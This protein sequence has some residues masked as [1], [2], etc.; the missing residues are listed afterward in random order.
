MSSRCGRSIFL[1]MFFLSV[2][3]GSG[4]R[5]TESTSSPVSTTPVNTAPVNTTPV[6]GGPGSS[7]SQLIQ[8]I[9]IIMQENRTFDHMFNGFPGADTVQGGMNGNVQ[10]PLTQIRLADP[11]NVYNTHFNWW[12]Q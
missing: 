11:G 2:G 9:V 4:I 1:L 3:C 10:V 12:I 8:H 6:S 7:P 5:S